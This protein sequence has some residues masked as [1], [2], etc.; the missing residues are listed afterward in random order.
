MPKLH[1]IRLVGRASQAS[2]QERRPCRPQSRIHD[3][4]RLRPSARLPARRR[5]PRTQHLDAAALHRGDIPGAAVADA[6]V[7]P[8]ELRRAL[9]Q[10]V[11][12]LGV[13]RGLPGLH[14]ATEAAGVEPGGVFAVALPGA[15]RRQ[16]EAGQARV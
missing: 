9:L 5:D 1:L 13:R 3:D 7:G 16:S 11:P 6:A 2:D 14:G 4:R 15:Q 8:A 12:V 10:A